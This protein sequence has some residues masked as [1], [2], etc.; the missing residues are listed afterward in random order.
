[1]K[2]D[3]TTPSISSLCR[4]SLLSS[5]N[6]QQNSILPRISVPD[7]SKAQKNFPSVIRERVEG[8][9]KATFTNHILIIMSS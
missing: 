5:P 6:Y 3:H 8:A 7:L 1:M 4:H 9:T 2:G